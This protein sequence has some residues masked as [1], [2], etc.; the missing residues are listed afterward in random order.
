MLKGSGL[1][2]DLKSMK[3]IFS[4]KVITILLFVPFAQGL[5]RVVSFLLG[6][7]C[8]HPKVVLFNVREDLAVDCDGNTL[9]PREVS[10]Q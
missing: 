3:S 6:T 4:Q 2:F 1:F 5:N 9:S 10:S 8:L 7:K